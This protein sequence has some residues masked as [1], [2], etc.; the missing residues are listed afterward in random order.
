M[1]QA[2][3]VGCRLVVLLLLLTTS[4]RRVRAESHT[5]PLD[6]MRLA[7]CRVQDGKIVLGEWF[8]QGDSPS[9]AVEAED[10]VDL[11]ADP[12]RGVE[13]A[14]CS[15]GRCV[16]RVDRAL[17][18]VQVRRAGRYRRWSRASASLAARVP[19]PTPYWPG[20]TRFRHRG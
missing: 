20:S 3:L 10:A 2:L 15:G 6:S 13:D 14:Q 19:G 12:P 17:F 1:K 4:P 9:L 5:F 7:A 11:L 18:P 8:D 16:V